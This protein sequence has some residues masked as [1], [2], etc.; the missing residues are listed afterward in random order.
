MQAMMKMRAKAFIIGG[1]C[2]K[3]KGDVG[4]GVE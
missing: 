2:K 3:E 1:T 4:R